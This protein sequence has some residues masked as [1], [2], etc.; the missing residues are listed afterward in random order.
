MDR[1][2]RDGGLRR[3]LDL[4]DDLQRIRQRITDPSLG[5]DSLQRLRRQS[6]RKSERLARTLGTYRFRGP[7]GQV[8]REFRFQP[9]HFQVLATLLHRHLH[10]ED[11]AVEGRLLLGTVFDN[12]YDVLAGAELLREGGPLRASGLVVLDEDEDPQGDVLEARFKIAEEAL[13]AF[14]E[15]ASTLVP[16]DLRR[17]PGSSYASNREFL[18]DLR[19]LHN[20]YRVRSERL[21]LLDRWDRVHTRTFDP[22]RSLSRRITSYWERVQRRLAA[23]PEAKEFP[24]VRFLRTWQLEQEE[25]IVVI[26]LLFQELYEGIAHADAA[27]LIRLISRSEEDLIRNRLLVHP[28]S[29]LVTSHILELEPFL[30]GRELTAE[31]HLNDWVVNDLFGLP[32]QNR[33]IHPDERLDW[34]LYLK[35]LDDSD[36][37]FRDMDR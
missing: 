2:K 20:L 27:A 30:E 5:R 14:R 4:C 25:L 8:L 31:V 10:H 26:H 17:A 22:G 13:A 6:Q 3:L 19:I 29:R 15:E 28:K 34:H 18:I 16:E 7:L 21:F 36:R 12:S 9:A 24:V 32:S 11:P 35:Q 23:S 33:A 37:F 1:S